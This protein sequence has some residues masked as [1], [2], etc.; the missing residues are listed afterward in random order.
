[1]ILRLLKGRVMVSGL[2]KKKW[3]A[4][5]PNPAPS[6]TLVTSDFIK[7]NN[8]YPDSTYLYLLGALLP[9]N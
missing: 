6:Q 1:M 4:I 7:C 2:F 9:N 8:L 5:P 3:D